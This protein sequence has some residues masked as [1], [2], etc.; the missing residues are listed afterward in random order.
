MTQNSISCGLTPNAL[1]S[2]RIVT[3]RGFW[4]FSIRLIFA[5]DIP[6]ALAKSSWLNTLAILSSLSVVI[7][8]IIAH[9]AYVL[10]SL[11]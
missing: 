11:E 4:P 1:A 7:V 2:L 5:A 10:A 3:K 9:S 8:N 6:T